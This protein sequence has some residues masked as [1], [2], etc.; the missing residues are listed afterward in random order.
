MSFY[1]SLTGLNAASKE[2]SVTANNIA[3]SGTTSFKRSDADFG[4][5]FASSP[6]QIATSVVGLG[7]A[8]KDVTQEFSQGSIEFSANSLDLAIT[9]D[10]FFPLLAQDGSE[11]FTRNGTFM[12]DQNS[13]V[14]DSAGQS[15]VA[16]EV[17]ST[18]K[19]DFSKPGTALTIPRQTIAEFI[20]T[21]EVDLGLNLPSDAA[22]ISKTFDPADATTYNKSSS[23]T[24]YGASGTSHLATVYYVKTASATAANP[25]N[26]W[27]SHVYIDNQ[28]VDSQ[29]IQA[30][31]SAG[32]EYF[33][34]KYGEVKS[35]SELNTL[36]ATSTN[37]QEYMIAAGAK[38]KKYSYDDLA[39]PTDSK[40]ASI[41]FGVAAGTA[42]ADDLNRANG[43]AGVDFSGAGMSR[44]ALSDMFTLSIDDSPAVSIG[45]E[46]LAGSTKAMSGT[47]IA[48]ALTNVINE[49]LGD[50]K[51]FDFSAAATQPLT[52][53]RV[54]DA[55]DETATNLNM[56]TLLN[57]Y[58]ANNTG[59]TAP[60]P[61]A[62][63][64]TQAL[65]ATAGTANDFSD[66]EVSY[67][68]ASQGFRFKQTGSTTDS[69]YLSSG[70]AGTANNDVFGVAAQTATSK[71]TLLTAI[72]GD[73]S[74]TLLG[75]VVPNGTVITTANNQRYGITV[76]YL[77]GEFLLS[78]GSTGDTS[79]LAIGS[80]SAL[81][82]SLLGVPAAGDQVAAETSQISNVPA[83]RGQAGMPAELVGKQMVIDPKTSFTVTSANQ[84]MSV[85]ID[86]ISKQ[87]TIPAGEYSIANFTEQMET[88]INLLAD[89][90]GR[91]VSGVSVSY[92]QDTGG[93]VITGATTTDKSFVQIAG[94]ADWGLDGLEAAFGKSS[95]YINLVAD[96][97]AAGD[98]YVTQ[99]ADGNWTETQAAA[100]F[101]ATDVP[102][103]TPI[104]LD[105]GELTFDTSGTLIS[106]VGGT[107]LDSADIT[108]GDVSLSFKGTTQYSSPFAI[109]TQSQNGAPEG[110]LVDINVSNDGLVVASYSNGSQISL[111]KIALA[112]FTTPEGLRQ[113][114]DTNYTATSG[115]GVA[116]MDEAGSAG[117][118]G[119][120]AGAK[121][122]SNVDL[123]SELIALISAQRN[124]QANAKAIETNS[125]LTQT[126]INIRG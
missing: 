36:Q 95:T 72:D 47:E 86:G 91:S 54:T 94:H 87:V 39:N 25:L 85:I 71:G 75:A 65:K 42:T 112:N 80:P 9:G 43:S 90:A 26:K 49:R 34:N 97:N 38:Y 12:L 88:Q 99:G 82:Q 20:P 110:D 89:S 61:L 119:I 107:A 13:N 114:G 116:L 28:L 64:M 27:Q 45:L 108:G 102:Y 48:F 57:T 50:G 16:Y 83:V 32:D 22:V 11:V 55:G 5:I 59:I 122:G 63:A 74:D 84:N 66:L 100:G 44:A 113:I 62:Y 29:L 67:D 23:I 51:N 40:A 58:N 105:K 96:S 92:D 81:G 19:I 8:L 123:T 118:G 4:D 124:F 37:P 120:R 79:S 31:D 73:G 69:L 93:L 52:I 78:S 76:T 111:G 98:F 1:T 104:F 68:P 6:I 103:W 2:L 126:I 21:T 125:S 18:N 101:T 77:N 30:S 17:D 106:P 53:T 24:V 117:Y 35:R 56:S 109:K 70:A 33:V 46:H 14:V 60:E 121:E 3:N 7:V 115:S 15:L 10:G 41:N